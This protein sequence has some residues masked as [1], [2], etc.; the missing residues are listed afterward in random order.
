MA[1]PSCPAM[2]RSVNANRKP[3]K[4]K[5]GYIALVPYSDEQWITFFEMGNRPG[6]FDD[7]RFSTYS[8]R[9]ENITELYA[10]I[11]EVALTKT[12]D[13]WL[14]L[15]D[16]AN[17]PAMRFNQMA[18]VLDDEHLNAAGFFTTREHPDAGPYRSMSH[19][20]HFSQTPADI[21][22]DPPT[23]GAD[24]ETLLASLGLGQH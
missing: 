4:T 17:I 12:T 19:P 13:D 14:A 8:A 20:V 2:A 9:T 3:Y 10:I 11:A 21:A 24:T 5:D 23:L 15:L 7:P 16:K 18:D 1:R 6:V 22:R